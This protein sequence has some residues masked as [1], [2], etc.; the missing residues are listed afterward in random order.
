ME[1]STRR[2]GTLAAAA[3]IGLG[4]VALAW[5]RKVVPDPGEG[6]PIPWDWLPRWPL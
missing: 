3:A 4:A 6:W 1:P 2:A 5:N